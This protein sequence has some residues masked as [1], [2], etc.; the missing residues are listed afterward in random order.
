[1]ILEKIAFSIN[2]GEKVGLIGENG[3]GKTTL[4]KLIL[5]QLN[6]D[7][8]SVILKN[9]IKIGYL[10]QNGG[11]ESGNTVYEEMREIFAEEYAA[12]DKLSALSVKLSEADYNSKDYNI[13][14]AKIESL[15]KYLVAH[16]C[17]DVDVKIKTVLNGMG[18]S[19]FYDRVIDNMSGGEKTRLK[20]ARLLLE[21][22]DILILDEPT[23]HL[24]I[25]T[26]FWLEDYLSTFKGAVFVV[27]HD[28]YFLDRIVTRILEVENKRLTSFKGNYSKYKV[29]KAELFAR[30]LKEYEAQQEE[31]AKLQDY[32]DRNIVRATTAKSAQSR[33]KQLDKMEIL[34]KPYTPP[35]PPE[36]IFKYDQQSYESVLDIQNLNLEIGGKRLISGGQLSLVRGNK[37]AIVGENGTGKST[38][39]KT[40][41]AGN[42]AI[43][44]GRFVKI[45][46][47]DQE[48]ANL[49]GNNT[50]LD[51][52]WN[53]HLGLTQTEVR[54]ALARCGL[55]AEDMY[56]PVKAL[57]GGERAKLALCILECERANT[58]VLDEPTNHLD[59]PAR[60][61][62]ER[63]LKKFDGTLIFVSH[64][65]YFIS[66]IADRVVEIEGGK[67]NYYEGGYEYYNE[68]KKK[69]VENLRA[70]EE[71]RLYAQ[72]DA[73]RE[74]SFR[75]KK[76]RAE[77]E[78]KKAEIKKLESEIG[79]L[80]TE[81]EEINQSL[82]NPDILCDY[83][84]VNA[85]SA[86]LEQ[87]KADLDTLYNR[88]A[89]MI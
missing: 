26:M 47:Y 40:I 17:F 22:P 28:R 3:T 14:S 13:I 1:L 66:A 6:P 5:G 7:S 45:G 74:K 72:K 88:Y 62:L 73:E 44:V 39:L 23:N 24:D 19:A 48:G 76:E 36:Y 49:D 69:R 87:I 63:A 81:E 68:E 80:E 9:G 85:L 11:Y 2:E 21:G 52:L 41:I 89:D 61:S 84:K 77:S 71:A 58:I 34:E 37:L 56:K 59:L 29:L 43:R 16:D 25:T 78:R 54:A 82:A 86:R 79:E 67:L 53:R 75:T 46:Y 38:L 31:R 83:V 57:S 8:G 60:E 55:F 50:V 51:E 15:N 32:V 27:S 12:V 65:R 20:L 33:V 30:Q 42:P 18:F 35:T 70:E 64:D 4:I 10:E